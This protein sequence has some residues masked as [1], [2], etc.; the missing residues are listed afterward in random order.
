[1]LL[2][3]EGRGFEGH[4]GVKLR[5]VR[6]GTHRG[7]GNF[8]SLIDEYYLLNTSRMNFN[9]NE[10]KPSVGV[11]SGSI[12]RR[13]YLIYIMFIDSL[14]KIGVEIKCLVNVTI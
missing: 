8:R 6:I 2:L 12:L 11:S 9:R 1:M 4:G 7:E 13:H 5:V 14:Y 3:R 10:A